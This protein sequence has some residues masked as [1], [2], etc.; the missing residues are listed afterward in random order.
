MAGFD[1]PWDWLLPHTCVSENYAGSAFDLGVDS[2]GDALIHCGGIVSCFPLNDAQDRI[3]EKY[4]EVNAD[5][6]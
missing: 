4:E 1:N 5:A 6:Q 3:K 2:D